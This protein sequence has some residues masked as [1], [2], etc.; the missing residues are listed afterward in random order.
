MANYTVVGSLTDVCLNST[1]TVTNF[2]E[3]T[4]VQ[5]KHADRIGRAVG[6]C[7]LSRVYPR[8]GLPVALAVSPHLNIPTKS[9]PNYPLNSC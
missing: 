9:M 1:S 8:S 4:Q 7:R 3:A 5:N 2:S 6:S